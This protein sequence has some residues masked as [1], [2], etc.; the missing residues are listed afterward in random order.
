M[1]TYLWKWARL[2]LTG[3]FVFSS[4]TPT[5]YCIDEII[6][7]YKRETKLPNT[8]FPRFLCSYFT[9]RCV[10]LRCGL[11]AAS[12]REL[13]TLQ[14]VVIF[15]AACTYLTPAETRQL[16]PV[17]TTQIPPCAS[18]LKYQVKCKTWN[19]WPRKGWL[20]F[21]TLTPDSSKSFPAVLAYTSN[22]NFIAVGFCVDLFHPD[23]K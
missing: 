4:H 1:A 5:W 17:S 23:G 22:V 15:Y 6:L 3:L 13:G 7:L 20:D 8:E 10:W 19:I 2:F 16:Q 9:N 12:S 14:T 11:W 21:E 18:V